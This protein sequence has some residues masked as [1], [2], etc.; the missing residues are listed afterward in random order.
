MPTRTQSR[1]TGRADQGGKRAMTT[2]DVLIVVA[3][4]LGPILAVGGMRW[5]DRSRDRRDRQLALFRTL[6][7]TRTHTATAEHIQAL[8]A[9]DVEFSPSRPSE[10]AV[11]AAW[12]RHAGHQ[13]PSDLSAE[14]WDARRRAGLADLLV[15]MGAALGYD[16]D[17]E[18]LEKSAAARTP[19]ATSTDLL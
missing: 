15:A 7:A 17:R 13:A 3:I 11:L 19:V 1:K 14:D 2:P 4:L 18:H 5:L 8:N 16:L 9:I 10:A 6:M 12:R